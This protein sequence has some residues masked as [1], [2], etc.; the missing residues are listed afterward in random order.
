[1]ND[2]YTYISTL[3]MSTWLIIVSL[4]AVAGYI[5]QQIVESRILTAMFMLAFQTG[6]LFINYMSYEFEVTPL[7]EPEVNLIALSTVGM[8]VALLVS[9]I[10]MRVV[11]A[12]A[13]ANRHK[14]ERN[15]N[16]R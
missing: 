16:P 3:N 7:R 10:L 15:S 8:V 5:M 9:L 12:I 14:V 11:N 13:D 4:V 1:M 2:F 6:A